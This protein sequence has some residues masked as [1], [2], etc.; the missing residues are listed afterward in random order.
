[1]AKKAKAKEAPPQRRCY[2]C[3]DPL[4]DGVGE[5]RVIARGERK[6]EKV[7]PLCADCVA[8]SEQAV[9]LEPAEA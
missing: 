3:E 7:G 2:V 9:L 8:A 6:G 4:P 5:H 1:M